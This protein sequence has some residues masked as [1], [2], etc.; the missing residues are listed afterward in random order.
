L[1]IGGIP[2]VRK[3]AGTSPLSA[4]YAKEIGPN[5]APIIKAHGGHLLAQAG[6]GGGMGQIVTTFG[7]APPKRFALLQFADEADCGQRGEAAEL[8]RKP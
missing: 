6:A 3:I 4:A 7:E 5:F 8:L 1:L 2:D